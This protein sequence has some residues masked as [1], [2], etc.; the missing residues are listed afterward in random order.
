MHKYSVAIAETGRFSEFPLS[1]VG[2]TAYSIDQRDRFRALA[3][4]LSEK[5]NAA[6]RHAH[7]LAEAYGY[8]GTL[9]KPSVKM[10]AE[11]FAAAHMEG[12][13]LPALLAALD[14]AG[15]EVKVIELA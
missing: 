8:H 12:E 15:Y 4:E 10:L 11:I 2:V 7:T 9:D 1:G 13:L 6:A 5:S 3:D 14:V